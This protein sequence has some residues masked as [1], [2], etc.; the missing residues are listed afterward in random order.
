[1]KLLPCLAICFMPSADHIKVIGVVILPPKVLLAEVPQGLTAEVIKDPV[2]DSL[3]GKES[4]VFSE[5]TKEI[6]RDPVM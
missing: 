4:M 3:V 6:T 1:M 2:A 5:L